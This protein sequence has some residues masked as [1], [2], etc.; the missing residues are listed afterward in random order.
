MGGNEHPVRESITQVAESP[1]REPAAC[2]IYGLFTHDPGAG[3]CFHL[4][5][6]CLHDDIRSLWKVFENQVRQRVD[7][8]EE[9]D[10]L[11]ICETSGKSADEGAEALARSLDLRGTPKASNPI[12]SRI[13]MEHLYERTRSSYEEVRR[14]LPERTR[15]HFDER[16]SR[17]LFWVYDPV[18][19]IVEYFTGQEGRGAQRI[20]VGTTEVI[21]AREVIE[22]LR[23]E[24]NQ[25]VYGPENGRRVSLD[26]GVI[27]PQVAISRYWFSKDCAPPV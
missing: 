27:P 19:A 13:R 1:A 2:L 12:D 24:W 23:A 20:K 4:Q 7:K 22:A 10:W 11:D 17:W 16:F 14:R 26:G 9:A 21:A 3:P 5:D 18:A 15:K 25:R 6:E 8:F